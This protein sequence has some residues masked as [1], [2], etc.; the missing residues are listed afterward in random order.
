METMNRDFTALDLNAHPELSREDVI[1]MATAF[2]MELGN[3]RLD[4]FISR[5]EHMDKVHVVTNQVENFGIYWSKV[6]SCSI[7]NPF[8]TIVTNA[9]VAWQKI[10]E[11]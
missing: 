11:A 5:D 9:D 8:V 7:D 3:A 6:L 10:E 2:V 1:F 4:G